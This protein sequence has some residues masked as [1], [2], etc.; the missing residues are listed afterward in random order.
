[1]KKSSFLKSLVL[2][3]AEAGSMPNNDDANNIK[4]DVL[5]F[6]VKALT[7]H[8]NQMDQVISKI[9]EKKD[10]LLTRS[11]KLNASIEE[12]TKKL[13]NLENEIKKLKNI[14]TT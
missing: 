12:I 5:E 6:A 14:L 8:E 7:K 10:E 11:Q 3:K 2:K 13:D 4:S 9:E 1:M